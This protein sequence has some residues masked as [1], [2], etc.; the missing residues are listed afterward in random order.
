L[1][2]LPKGMFKRGS[3]YYVR[4]R[5][6]GRDRWI[7]LGSDREEAD[8]KL[9]AIRRGE[10]PPAERVTVDK[11]VPRWL[12][13]YIGTMR[14]EKCQKLAKARTCRYLIPFMGRLLLDK[15]TGE[16]L[17]AYRL[18]LE[19]REGKDALAP[20][21]VAHI[22]SDARCF[23]NW[24]EDTGLVT[25]S[26]VPRKLLPRIQERPPDRLT[27]EEVAKL[28]SL[29][30]PYGFTIRLALAT[31]LRWGELTRAQASH[32]ENRQLIVSK[33]KTGRVRRVPLSPELLEELRSRVGK[34]VPFAPK[35]SGWF[36]TIARRLS[37]VERFHPHQTRHTFACRWL[38]KGGSLAALQ[39]VLGHTTVVTTQRYARLTDEY[40]V[41][42]AKR[43]HAAG[44]V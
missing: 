23:F 14:D 7:G 17:R 30:E 40:V 42:E 22:L 8:G 41:E 6:C 44:Q 2:R 12:E 43:V 19:R 35:S 9:R 25:R 3:G 10:L 39:Q 38:E 4:I 27:D 21:S 18:W 32:V 36:A 26:P 5:Q 29:P 11:V 13:S 16:D 34:L 24:C 33:T 28:V 37:G 20:Q 31:G 15:V 1:P